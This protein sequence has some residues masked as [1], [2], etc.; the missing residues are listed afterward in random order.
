MISADLRCYGLIQSAVMS[1]AFDQGMRQ[2]SGLLVTGQ[3]RQDL[4]L[5]TFIKIYNLSR[6][7]IYPCV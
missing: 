4:L 2:A 6:S 3:D 1:A 5:T 7:T